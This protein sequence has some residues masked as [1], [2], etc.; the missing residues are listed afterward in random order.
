MAG[1][2]EIPDGVRTE[3]ERGTLVKSAA[4]T[5]VIRLSVAVRA[6][7][8]D[9]VQL[10]LT[11]QLAPPAIIGAVEQLLKETLKSAAFVPV[12]VGAWTT[13]GP[14]PMFVTVTPCA[15]VVTPMAVLVK[16][17]IVGFTDL[18]K[19]SGVQAEYLVAPMRVS[20]CQGSLRL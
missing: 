14:V 11:V 19:V 17:S 5:S 3:Q 6:P 8:A 13:S 9:G 20:H 1:E 10:I 16:T 7:E 4:A 2:T 15:G 12:I 18:P